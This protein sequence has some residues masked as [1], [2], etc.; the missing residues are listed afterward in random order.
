MKIFRPLWAEGT[1]LSSQQFQQQARWEAYSNNSIAQLGIRHPWGVADVA[2]DRA[3]LALGK[4]KA[5]SLRLRFP[6]GSLIDS[7]V[8]DLLPPACDLNAL[9][10]E[11]AVT[12]TTGIHGLMR[13]IEET[14]LRY[15]PRLSQLRVELLPQPRPGHL[16]YL[17]HAQLPDTGWIRFDGIFSPEG[18]IVL[19]HLKQQERAF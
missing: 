4:L 2:F 14:L 8:S 3:A 18:R 1:Y 15:E 5:V 13:Q 17:I 6:D 16:N 11:G 7:E 9:A 12:V 19:R 10:T